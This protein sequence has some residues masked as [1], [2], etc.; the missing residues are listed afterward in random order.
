[1][2]VVRVPDLATALELV[3]EHEYGNGSARARSS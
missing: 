3:N 2:C 1:L